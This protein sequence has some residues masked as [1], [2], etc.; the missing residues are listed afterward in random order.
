METLADLVVKT[1]ELAGI[2]KSSTLE[3][4]E[5]LTQANHFYRYDVAEGERYLV[6]NNS[7][8]DVNQIVYEYRDL[9]GGTMDKNPPANARDMGLIP[10]AE[11]SH[12]LWSN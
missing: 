2:V 10:R 6:E 3:I 4:D 11:R 5:S 7:Y 1:S 9:P 12:M 8:F